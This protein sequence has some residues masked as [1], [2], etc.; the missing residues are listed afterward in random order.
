MRKL[1]KYFTK[2]EWVLLSASLLVIILF[3]FLFHGS[4]PFSF[5][6]SLIGVI[7]LVLCAKGNPIGQVLMFLFSIMYGFISWSFSYYGEMLTYMLMTAPMALF[8]LVSWL[9]HP[10]KGNR[11]EVTVGKMSVKKWG[12]LLSLT[13]LVTFIF[14]FILRYFHTANLI[15]STLSVATSFLASALTFLRCPYFALAYAA[16]DIVLIV[17][18]TLASMEDLSY[19]SVVVCFATFFVNDIY[20]F[21]CWK[22]MERRQT[23]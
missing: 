13:V 7:S 12:V 1:F 18:W 10:Y 4:D 15:P 22:R 23:E 11:S 9:L 14:Y 5:A 8:S 3:Q 6:S 16:N 20:G 17:L 19:V 2:G 21:I